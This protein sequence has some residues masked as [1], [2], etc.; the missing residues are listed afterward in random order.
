MDS[1]QNSSTALYMRDIRETPLLTREE[2]IAL[3]DRIEKGGP[4]G[5]KAR[6]HMIKANLRLV[7]KIA[8]NYKNYGLPQADLISEGN[9]GLMTATEKFDHEKG[10]FSTY[11]AWWIKQ[12]ITRSLT[13][14]SKIIRTPAH[15]LDKIS[16]IKRISNTWANEIGQEP[17]EEQLAEALGIPEERIAYIKKSEI[18]MASLDAPMGEPGNNL[19]TSIQDPNAIAPSEASEKQSDGAQIDQA[20]KGLDPRT[21]AIIE[22]RFG[23]NGEVA[24]TLQEV[25]RDFGVSRERI[26]QIQNA[27][28]AAMKEEIKKSH[29]SE[30]FKQRAEGSLDSKTIEMAKRGIERSKHEG[31]ITMR[32]P[33]EIAPEAIPG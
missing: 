16:R 20:L 17:T 12:S 5:E 7:V 8:G 10:K 15:M 13:D 28:L 6:D 33:N 29:L 26:R 2:E 25:S 19:G 11:A 30:S 4:D 9:I 23:L 32:D 18:N 31:K 14:K 22:S 21:Y 24:R 1:T 27:G 3:A